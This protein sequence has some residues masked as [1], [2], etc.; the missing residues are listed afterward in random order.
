M[1]TVVITSGYFNPLHPGH[2]ECFELC[3]D[4]GDELRVI[5]NTDEQIR[6]KT[7]KNDI[8]QDE[9]FRMKVVSSLKTVDRVILSVDTDSSLCESI[10]YVAHQIRSE[11]SPDVKIIFGKGGDRFASNIPE[12]QVCK[13]LGIDI[14]DGLGAKTHNSSD[15][16]TKIV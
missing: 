7:G 1:K 2:I 3:K 9:G 12:V 14:R 11:Y 6:T 8:F 10:R 5:V 15:Y 4:L 13:E 16:R